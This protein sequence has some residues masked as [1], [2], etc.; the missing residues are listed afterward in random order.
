MEMKSNKGNDNLSWSPRGS[1]C[2]T[3]KIYAHG[4]AKKAHFRSTLKSLKEDIFHHKLDFFGRLELLLAPVLHFSPETLGCPFTWSGGSA[5]ALNHSFF[6]CGGRCP[7]ADLKK[8]LCLQEWVLFSAHQSIA[9]GCWASLSSSHPGP[10]R[11]IMA[12]SWHSQGRNL[13]VSS[14]EKMMFIAVPSCLLWTE[15]AFHLDFICRNLL[16]MAQ[17]KTM[18]IKEAWMWMDMQDPP[19][20]LSMCRFHELEVHIG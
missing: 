7:K 20:T 11:K 13:L 3:I 6:P 18:V 5:G 2:Q 10:L 19:L 4:C 9:Y 14:R 12:L 15:H 8:R 17:H 16:H 1:S